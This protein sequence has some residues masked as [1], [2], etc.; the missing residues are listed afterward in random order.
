MIGRWSPRLPS[1]KN[2][3]LLRSFPLRL[4][5]DHPVAQ[6]LAFIR[7]MQG[8]IKALFDSNLLGP[9]CLLDLVKLAV[10]RDREVVL[11]RPLLRDAEDPV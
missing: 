3:G 5:H 6:I 8:S 1:C 9:G 10:V 2:K 4:F 7:D 11:D